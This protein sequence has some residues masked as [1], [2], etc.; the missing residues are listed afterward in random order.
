MLVR[1][2]YSTPMIEH[3]I[4][5][6]FEQLA[7][8]FYGTRRPFE[9]VVDG[10][11]KGDEYVLTVDLPGIPASAVS[12]D[13]TGDVLAIG[14]STDSMTWQRSL[15]LGGR[16]DPEKVSARHVDG[17][18]TLN[19][20]KVDE[21]EA[22]RIAIDTSRPEPNLAIEAESS[23]TDDDVTNGDQSTDTNDAG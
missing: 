1:P 21:P 3:S 4:D 14:V 20:G 13:V 22:R 19:V 6:A 23:D 12:V 7:N 17:R 8:S 9:P 5:R 11:W 16:L 2:R 15:R 18:L 10:A